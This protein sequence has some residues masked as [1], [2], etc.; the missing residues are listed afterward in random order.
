MI[1]RP[2]LITKRLAAL[3]GV[4]LG[5]VAVLMLARGIVEW[6]LPWPPCGWKTLTGWP[7]PLCGGTRALA[8]WAAGD[9][10]QAFRWNPFVAAL[11]ILVAAA[12]VW[13]SVAG[14]GAAGATPPLVDRRGPRGWMLALA[15]IVVLN[16]IYL[17]RTLPR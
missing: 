13:R 2:R 12:C 15:A 11:P 4:F 1:K 5:L 6:R 3:A 16:W 14:P 8:C 9:W 10:S 17:F 7:C